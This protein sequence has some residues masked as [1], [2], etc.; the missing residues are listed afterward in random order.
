MQPGVLL[1]QSRSWH[2]T[3]GSPGGLSLGPWALTIGGICEQ[4]L[5]VLLH[6]AQP[7]G[8]WPGAALIASTVCKG[9][10]DEVYYVRDDTNVTIASIWS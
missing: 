8:G 4:W 7:G 1:P 2:C 6:K 3:R 5:H 9:G 10:R